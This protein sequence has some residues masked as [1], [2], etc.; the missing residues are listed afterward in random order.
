M[1]KKTLATFLIIFV[2]YTVTVT[3]IV[4]PNRIVSE[5]QWQDNQIKVQS[6]L[7][8]NTDS[9][10]AVIVGSSLSERIP[11]HR[12]PNF[13]NLGLQGLGPID[14]LF[15][16]AY[17]GVY[18]KYILLEINH[19]ERELNKELTSSIDNPLMT[20]L[21]NHIVSLRDGKQPMGFIA[22]PYG[23]KAVAY[24]IY[25][26]QTAL[27]KIAP[28]RNISNNGAANIHN[29][30]LS[31]VIKF[32]QEIPSNLDKQTSIIQSYLNDMSKKGVKFIFFEV[33]GETQVT[34]LDGPVSI[35]KEM[36]KM[37][38]RDKYLYIDLPDCKSYTTTDGEHL[39]RSSAIKYSEFLKQEIDKLNLGI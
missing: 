12:M 10:D 29:K 7:F 16:I 38:P 20:P 26:S 8:S 37:F 1:I 18:P 6:Y 30:V 9:L 33:P 5:H 23:Q 15:T 19:I 2:A 36:Y 24:S 31:G 35:R 13:F 4:D 28:K 22:L 17:K 27:H 11:L 3:Y 34:K 32:H 39:D 14:G 25:L 21:R